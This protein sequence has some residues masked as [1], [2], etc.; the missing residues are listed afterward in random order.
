VVTKAD[1]AR[2]GLRVG[3]RVTLTIRSTGPKPTQWRL[4][5]IG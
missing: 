4:C 5:P 3:D 2:L 1:M